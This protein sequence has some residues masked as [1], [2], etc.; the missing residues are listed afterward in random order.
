M[1][2]PVT[3]EIERKL[4]LPDPA[5]TREW[6]NSP[7]LPGY[8]VTAAG[9][10]LQHDV[11]LD[12]EDWRTYRWGYACRIRRS[13]RRSELILKS[14]GEE[15]RVRERTEI[16]QS[17][18]RSYR[19]GSPLPA[20]GAVGEKLS[21]IAGS[22]RLRPL[23]YLDTR[24]RKFLAQTPGGPRVEIAFDDCRLRPAGS[25]RSQAF[26]EIEVELLGPGSSESVDRVADLL[27][28]ALGAEDEGRTKFGRGLAAAGLDPEAYQQFGPA[29]FDADT[30]AR[31][32]VAALLRK[33]AQRMLREEAATR[34]GE[35]LEALHD[36]RVA[37]RRARTFLRI[38]GG[39]LPAA[40][41]AAVSGELRWLGDALGG[42]RDI[43]V[44]LEGFAA[45]PEVFSPGAEARALV[46][47]HLEE[48]RHKKR[49]LLLAALDS[50]RYRRL[51]RSLRTLLRPVSRM[52]GAQREPA[53][54]YLPAVAYEL[55]G[56]VVKRGKRLDAT[57]PTSELH[58]LRIKAK[59]ARYALESASPL[60]GKPARK[61]IPE[62]V[63]VQDHLGALQDAV[64]RGDLLRRFAVTL[65]TTIERQIILDLG[66]LI[67]AND[68]Q[69]LSLK[70]RFPSVFRR[71]AGYPDL[72]QL[73]KNLGSA[74]EARTAGARPLSP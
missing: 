17:L 41:V 53:G 14:F 1:P 20:D 40:R 59:R 69:L 43:D 24:R 49:N 39:V 73:M 55:L 51:V 38:Y 68:L 37:V 5:R 66:G 15:S 8:T 65:P 6:L 25:R 7:E 32:A 52:T 61:V 10:V 72:K 23:F 54:T 26:N 67:A 19:P 4:Q 2:G 18:P 3:L 58:R 63:R 48:V 64:V 60:L 46:R 13:G 74:F 31:E 36:M 34:L 16:A 28:Q 21:S 22:S 47:A 62:V 11:Y 71:F 12:T 29:T 27:V 33:Q 70:E 30:P 42:V 9:E 56:K 35:D 57:S 44:Q 45:D 50:A